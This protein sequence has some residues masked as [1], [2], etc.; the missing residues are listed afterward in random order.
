MDEVQLERAQTEIEIAHQSLI[1]LSAT[2]H[3][4]GGG[5]HSGDRSRANGPGTSRGRNARG[6]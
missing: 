5:P 3:S 1:D 2:K 4:K 6:R